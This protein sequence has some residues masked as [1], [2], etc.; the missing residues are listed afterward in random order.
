MLKSLPSR[1]SEHH[2][3]EVSVFVLKHSIYSPD[4]TLLH[5]KKLIQRNIMDDNDSE[6]EQFRRPVKVPLGLKIRFDRDP[7]CYSSFVSRP[8]ESDRATFDLSFS[9]AHSGSQ[10]AKLMVYYTFRVQFR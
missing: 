4:H 1:R 5:V 3:L 8:Q 6:N 2:S 10:N 9:R 7:T